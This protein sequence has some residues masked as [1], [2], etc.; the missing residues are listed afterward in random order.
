M[1]MG[2]LVESYHPVDAGH[3]AVGGGGRVNCRSPAASNTS[4]MMT[5]TNDPCNN[6]SLDINALRDGA[7]DTT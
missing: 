5:G 3:P 1:E 7:F 2:P 6:Y 4:A